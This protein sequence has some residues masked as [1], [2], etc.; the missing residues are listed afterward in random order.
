[1]KNDRQIQD[2]IIV[3]A[4]PAGLT[5][6][7]YLGRFR[8][9]CIVLED[10][11]SRAR[12][13]PT[14]HNIPGFTAGIGG[15]QFLTT[16]T[17]H[18][19]Q[20]GARILRSNVSSLAVDDQLFALAT[21]QGIF[22]AR[23]VVLATGVRDHLP[24]IH[25]ATEAVARSLLRLCPICDAFEA[26]DKRIAVIGDGTLGERE[27]EFLTHY[28]GSVTLLNIGSPGLPS[29]ADA[30]GSA[31]IER[32]SIQLSEVHIHEDRL[33][34]RTAKGE[35]HFDVAYLALGYSSRHDLAR[36]LGARCDENGAL[37]VDAHQQTTVPR[38]YAAGDVVRG[39]NQVVVAAAE[40]A[41]AATDI[42]NKLRGK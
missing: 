8:R 31:A 17:E 39:L 33:T 42:H 6:A 22:H 12:W 23:Y 36:S 4:G 29:A 28:S 9:R 3:G 16:L 5:A 18:A 2:V 40:S 37:Q 7:I 25:G 21:D 1:M 41:I 38:L 15:K 30:P 14:S 19:L 27:A 10:G 24:A 20:Y 11:Q 13:I 35:R 32:L 34:L 26:I